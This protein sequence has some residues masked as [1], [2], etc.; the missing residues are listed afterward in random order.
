MTIA[1]PMTF[2]NTMENDQQDIVNALA[3]SPQFAQ[4]GVC[5]SARNSGLYRSEDGGYTWRTALDSLNL[6]APLAV[7]AVA[8]SPNFAADRTVFAGAHGGVLSSCDGG[9]TWQVVM[10]PEPPPLV[11]SLALSPNYAADGILFAGTLEDGMFRSAD[12]GQ[13]WAAWNFGL[14]DPNVLV[15]AIAPDFAD[16]ATLYAGT[17]SG[18]FRSTNGGHS[19]R[20]VELPAEYPAVLAL[21]AGAGGAL[22]VGT[23]EDGLYEIGRA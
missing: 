8:V 11:T 22:F 7:S 1:E 12:R 18:L 5:F 20:D 17:S 2:M 3:A 16:T 10:L 6:E 19:W 13:T 15:V 21:A 23:E 14:L 4:D 9:E